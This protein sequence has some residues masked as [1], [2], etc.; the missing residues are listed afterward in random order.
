MTTRKKRW[1]YVGAG[2]S[3]VTI[4]GLAIAAS[5]LSR[6]FEPF[7]REQA[8]LYMSRRFN[9]DVELAALRIKMPKMSPVNMLLTRGRGASARV[10]GEGIAMRYKG[11]P[12]DAPPLFRIRDFSI[13]VDLGTLFDDTKKVDEVVLEGMEINVPPKGERRPLT[14]EQSAPASGGSGTTPVVLIREVILKNAK[15]TIVPK[16][17]AK[18]PLEFDLD[19][20]TLQSDGA[21]KPMRY[22][23]A[24]TNPKPKGRIQSS[25]TF[26]PWVADEPSATPLAGHYSFADADLSVFKSIAGMLQS[27]G[28]FEGVLSSLKARGEARV[29]DFRLT[30]A[31]NPVPLFTRFEVQVDGTNGNTVLQ[32]VNATL[33][34]TKFRTSG[35][36]IKHEGEKRRHIDLKVDMPSGNLRDVLR[37]AMKGQPFMEGKLYLKTSLSL[38]PLSGKVREKLRLDGEF[39]ISEG[40][41]LKSTI[42]DEIDKLSRRGQGAPK[43]EE[44]DEVVSGMNGSFHLENELITFRKLAFEVPGAQV[45]LAGDYD[46]DEDALDFLGTLKLRARVSQTMTGWKRIALKPVDPFFAK[47]GAGTFLR[48]AVDGTSRQPKFGLARNKKDSPAEVEAERARAAA[49]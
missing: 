3:V 17:R 43:S 6:R 35:A 10:E 37:L 8:I 23:A 27:T 19:R 25:G 21:G 22:E 28:S 30:M 44:I 38:P 11:A 14:A 9:C 12:A 20:V 18:A 26:G 1:L 49:K 29:P 13:K 46:L 34:S 7:I 41:F 45:D 15:L 32:P 39:R 24:L 2:V 47:E 33:G 42:Q 31:N 4:A 36:V 40:K 48:I 5:V 16:D